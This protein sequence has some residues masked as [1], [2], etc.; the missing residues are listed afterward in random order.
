MLKFLKRT[1]GAWIPSLIAALIVSATLVSADPWAPYGLFITGAAT[2]NA[3]CTDDGAGL[4]VIS[5]TL[6]CIAP[7]QLED[8]TLSG[9]G[10]GLN[11]T[12]L[13]TTAA[14]TSS[15]LHTMSSTTPQ[16]FTADASTGAT[17]VAVSAA[18]TG[19]LDT[20]HPELGFTANNT[21]AGTHGCPDVGTGA[22]NA[23]YQ[24]ANAANAAHGLIIQCNGGILIGTGASPALSTTGTINAGSFN[25]TGNG[26]AAT[27]T[28]SGTTPQLIFSGSGVN[29]IDF[30]ANTNPV[31]FKMTSGVGLGS[32]TVN[33][34]FYGGNSDV[35]LFSIAGNGN[36]HNVTGD[37]INDAGNFI[38]KGTANA[39]AGFYTGNAAV[40]S[41]AFAKGIL[42]IGS[43]GPITNDTSCAV[44]T[45]AKAVTML[46]GT[47]CKV[48]IPT[49]DIAGPFTIT[50]PNAYVT[51]APD[52]QVTMGTNTTPVTVKSVVPGLTTVVITMSAS[53]A[54]LDF[55]MM[56]VSGGK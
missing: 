17:G 13:T 26:S 56:H 42:A 23:M 24:F 33:Y 28:L 25:A 15:G 36:E 54:N 50:Y 45:T 41:G 35:L 52:V 7:T 44:T 46:N 3:G 47:D 27:L 4:H 2:S 51:T 20:T 48:T 14:I 31:N 12:T 37:T 30:A 38:A 6:L 21:T 1:A 55:F 16:L 43:T 8:L 32:T 40:G 10:T 22:A 9:A 18:G 11:V 39:T 29:E 53:V 5:N 34:G 19:V 49:A